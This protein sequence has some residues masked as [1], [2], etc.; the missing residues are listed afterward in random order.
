MTNDQPLTTMD[1]PLLGIDVGGPYDQQ[2]PSTTYS[3]VNVRGF[4]PATLRARGGSRPGLVKYLGQV[5][6][7][8]VKIQ[9]LDFIVDP[10]GDA[11]TAP[12]D[13]ETPGIE[14][15]DDNSSNNFKSRN[16][17][18]RRIR[19]GGNGF[20]INAKRPAG[21][22][23]K[24]T[25]NIVWPPHGPVVQPYTLTTSQLNAVARDPVTNVIVAGAYVYSPAAGAS[26]TSVTVLSVTFTPADTATYNIAVGSITL[27]TVDNYSTLSNGTAV[28]TAVSVSGPSFLGDFDTVM[29]GVGD[30]G[31]LEPYPDLSGIV[32]NSGSATVHVGDSVTILVFNDG[33]LQ[34]F[35]TGGS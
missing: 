13:T 28:C 3:G 34:Y 16:P 30:H 31:V 21:V 19:K 24:K 6:A 23:T 5:G 20:Q 10:Q 15:I 4:E 9:H 22:G 8:A 35:K 33:S 27:D 32:R 11:L 7:G 1:F 17:P 26:I 29:L 2:R 14:Y 12:D 25:P 18:G